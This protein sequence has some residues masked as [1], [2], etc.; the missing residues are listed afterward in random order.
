ME[1]VLRG[2][3]LPVYCVALNEDGSR[4]VSGSHDSTVRIWNVL[5]AK[6]DVCAVEKKKD[7]R[8]SALCVS[9]DRKD[10][11]AGYDDGGISA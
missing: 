11:V 4:V 10:V 9:V 5:N 6:D 8:A 7:R 2:P 3:T 1:T